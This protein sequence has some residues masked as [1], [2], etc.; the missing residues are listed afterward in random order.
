MASHNLVKGMKIPKSSSVSFCEEC[1]EMKMFKK[2]YKPLGEIRSTRKFQCVHS[3]VCGPMSTES[4]GEKRYFVAFI[5]DYS[6]C[7]K[8]YF[9]RKI[10]KY[11]TNSKSLCCVQ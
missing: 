5:D 3:D 11:L 10:L 9:M 7:C 8:V 4:I 6:R 1:V 2:L